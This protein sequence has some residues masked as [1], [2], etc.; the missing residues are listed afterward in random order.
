MQ[1][2]IS[3]PRWGEAGGVNHQT[4]KIVVLSLHSNREEPV[5]KAEQ[6]GSAFLEA[7]PS[8]QQPGCS[9]L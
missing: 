8:F 2:A 5:S 7:L 9:D 3:W 6:R 1:Q 4:Q